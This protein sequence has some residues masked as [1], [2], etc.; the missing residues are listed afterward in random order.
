MQQ[1]GMQKTVLIDG[2][3]VPLATPFYRDGRLYVRKLEHNVARLSLTPVH[4][5]VA[6]TGEGSELTDTERRESLEAVRS[7]AAKEKVLVATIAQ[8]TVFAALEVAADAEAAEFDALLLQV[9]AVL[10]AT[11][12]LL[13]VR[14]IADVVTL[15]VLLWSGAGP[16]QLSI[17]T[18]AEL[19]LHPNV[20]GLYDAALTTERLAAIQA[21]TAQVQLEATVTT[22]FTPVTRRMLAPVVEEGASAT[23]VSAESLAGGTAVAVAPKVA[24]AIKTRTKIVGFQ[25]IAAGSTRNEVE[26]LEAGAA[27]VMPTLAASLPQACH[28]VYAAF[29][30]G[31]SALAALKAHR[32]D[33]ADALVTERGIA[34]VKYGSELAGYYGGAPRLPR[35][36][37]TAAERAQVESAFG[38]LRS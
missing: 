13:W 25:I 19:A 36:P 37:L 30:D 34:A 6:L 26:L 23:F 4:G 11:E 38:T 24:P 1:S 28:E 22:T 32:L 31:D 12:Q 29:K 18:I 8:P 35:L 2:L 14:S 10:S 9:P 20:H 27:G 15:P 3:H 21:A 33:A 7:V 5:L 16:A 17:E